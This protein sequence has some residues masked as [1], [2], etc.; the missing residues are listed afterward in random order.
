[1]WYLNNTIVAIHQLD[2]DSDSWSFVPSAPGTYYVFVRVTSEWNSMEFETSATA[3]V[4]V[5]G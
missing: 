5:L 4:I 2:A 1:M 3:I